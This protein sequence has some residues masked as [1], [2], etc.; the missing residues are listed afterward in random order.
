MNLSNLKLGQTKVTVIGD[1]DMVISKV[2]GGY[3]LAYG[4]SDA[5]LAYDKDAKAWVLVIAEDVRK[6]FADATA[7]TIIDQVA[8]YWNEPAT[9]AP[10]TEV[11]VVE[12]TEPVEL[13]KDEEPEDE[14]EATADENTILDWEV[15]TRGG[16]TTHR[17]AALAAVA[18]AM[19]GEV[20]FSQQDGS[21]YR[22]TALLHVLAP[23]GVV[24]ALE[25]MLPLVEDKMEKG[26]A[27]LSRTV[28]SQAR[29]AG[30]H[31]SIHGCHARRG[32]ILG[33]GRGLA[34][35]ILKSDGAKA[36][37]EFPEVVKVHMYTEAAYE[38]GYEAATADS[39]SA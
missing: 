17:A 26:A 21:G 29:A 7:K 36:E 34:E 13:V 35:K 25:L 30:Q 3:T 4:A 11:A 5:T 20:K 9:E 22:G 8:A 10:S 23:T 19:G 18:Y 32:Y 2:D 16:H 14:A 27:A 37:V 39:V 1:E 15:D 28:S 12:A 24:E 31:H 33:F 38:L 6:E